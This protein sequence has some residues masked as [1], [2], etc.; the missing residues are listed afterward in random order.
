MSSQPWPKMLN[1]VIAASKRTHRFSVTLSFAAKRS[2]D[3]TYT[4]RVELALAR[5]RHAG[6]VAHWRVVILVSQVG[7]NASNH[8]FVH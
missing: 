8:L 1:A 6:A 4:K 2:S 5:P 7:G 3:E